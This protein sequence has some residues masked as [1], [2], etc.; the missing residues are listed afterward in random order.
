MAV[1]NTTAAAMAA[2]DSLRLTE[3]AFSARKQA[4]SVVGTVSPLPLPSARLPL[5]LAPEE[6]ASATENVYYGATAA[7]AA[8][9]DHIKA[10][11]GPRSGCCIDDG[12]WEEFV[13]LAFDVMIDVGGRPFV[14]EVNH[15]PA[16]PGPQAC[17][18]AFY[19]HLVGLA[20][21]IVALVIGRDRGETVGTWIPVDEERKDSG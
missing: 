7:A 10:P 11:N 6:S 15:N 1:A 19:S 16:V 3:A 2:T 13:L 8:M 9:V 5:T 14:L 17:T 12:E 21:D 20:S 18:P 4:L